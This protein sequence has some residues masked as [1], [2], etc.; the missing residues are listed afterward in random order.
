M[1]IFRKFA[2]IKWP[3]KISNEEVCKKLNV[4]K[5]L[6][7]DRGKKIMLFWSHKEAVQLKKKS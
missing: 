1:W 6:V 2:N 7:N 5:S 3:D 4:G